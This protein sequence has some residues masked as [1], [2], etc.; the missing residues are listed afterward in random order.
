MLG[1]S[2]PTDFSERIW[3]ILSFDC[4]PTKRLPSLANSN[5]VASA[6][7]AA[8]PNPNAAKKAKSSLGLGDFMVFILRN[9]GRKPMG[10]NYC[11]GRV[12]R[13]SGQQLLHQFPFHIG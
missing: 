6:P 10:D 9:I 12:V 7:R 4:S 3:T 13:N 2:P 5:A 8:R 11:L 1:F